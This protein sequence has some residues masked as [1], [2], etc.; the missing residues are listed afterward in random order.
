MPLISKPTLWEIRGRLAQIIR[1]GLALRTAQGREWI[2]HHPNRDDEFWDK[3]IEEETHGNQGAADIAAVFEVI[4]RRG[5][6]RRALE[7][8]GKRTFDLRGA[9][10][11]GADLREA[12]LEHADLRGAHLEGSDLWRAHLEGA[13]LWDAHLE[14]SNLRDAH[15]EGAALGEAHLEG[16]DL[17]G[18]HLEGA[19]ALDE[20]FGDARTRLPEG[21][22]R[23]A[24]WPPEGMGLLPRPSC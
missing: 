20:A 14:G 19:S 8:R 13:R 24:H 16:A 17:R 2:S 9:I 21:V 12:H 6:D 23:P 11:R 1:A 4:K 7:T 15:L 10:L 22:E 3:A 18:A 5:D